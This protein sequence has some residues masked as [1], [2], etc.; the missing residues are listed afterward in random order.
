MPENKP[1]YADYRSPIVPRN[2]VSTL[3]AK[4]AALT[5]EIEE[6]RRTA[7]SNDGASL[8]SSPENGEAQPTSP[9][10][11]QNW[12]TSNL[13]KVVCEPSNQP[14][15]FGVS[16]G[17]T[18]ARLV[19]SA[20]RV[21]NLP[22]PL[23]AESNRSSSQTVQY[24]Y[25]TATQ[26]S[27]PPRQAAEHLMDVYFQNRTPS[28]PIIDRAQALKA[29]DG[30]Y[31]AANSQ[32]QPKREAS[33]NVF[34]TFM[35][36]AIA[37]C[38]VRHP[39]GG[40]PPESENCFLAA[41]GEVEKILVYSGSAT[42]SLRAILLLSQYIALR[43]SKGSLWLLSGTALRLAVDLGMHWETE[44]SKLRMDPI[45][46]NDRRRLW[47]SAYLFD[48]LLC[49]T[50][51]RPFGMADQGINVGLPSPAPTGSDNAA[52]TTGHDDHALEAHNSLIRLAQLQ[53][54]IKH[55]L[56]SQFLGS[57]LAYPRTDYALWIV[58]VRGRLQLWY[59]AIPPLREA[60]PSSIFS[61]Q[62]YWDAIYHDTLLLLYRPNP[63]QPQPSFEALQASFDSSRQL[64][65]CIKTLH[66]ERRIDIMW[67]WV[68]HLFIAGLT[69]IYCL[70]HSQEL[71]E[72]S[73]VKESV[74]TLQSCGATLSALA[75]RWD[76]AAGCRDA[77]EALSAATVSWLITTNVEE[78]QRSCLQFEKQVESLQHQLP[79]AFVQ[80]G[81]EGDPLAILSS[82]SFG[83]GET[84][85]S[86][87][88]WPTGQDG[89]FDSLD[90]GGVWASG[91]C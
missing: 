52:V 1:R 25:S 11:Y 88:E 49:I 43:P 63:V 75:E 21:D 73:D 68:H 84:L 46:L 15:F 65:A 81:F 31:I 42:E 16:S 19:M 86:A 53:S 71:R 72:N 90:Y 78:V 64:I 22:S 13:G 27:L 54:E 23:P 5:K 10:D 82:G 36:L 51:G 29:F 74:A 39:S 83:F 26:A 8:Q 59:N 9:N 85:S 24:P 47:Y 17:I 87:A 40:R 66:R 33:M 62:A 80:D 37:L 28:F 70:W 57:P 35:I 58:D 32:R 2:Y 67:K 18:L 44:E 20:I 61:S 41:I 7:P 6:L 38:S 34:T 91:D 60:H 89:N 48:R 56:Y 3:E 12:M 69:T 79:P 45:E 50:L 55:V 77:F 4:V 14:H 76:G 30:A